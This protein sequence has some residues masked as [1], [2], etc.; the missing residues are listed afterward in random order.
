MYEKNYTVTSYESNNKLQLKLN[1]LFQWFTEISWEH[2]KILGVGFEEMN[3]SKVFWVLI[4]VK[5]KINK[6]PKWQDKVTL[7]TAPTGINGLY[8]S[9]EFIL[10]D[11]DKNVLVEADSKWLIIDKN[12]LRTIKPTEDE[13]KN[14]K[15]K[16]KNLD[17]EFKRMHLQTGLTNIYK[18]TVQYTDIDL[19]NHVNNAVYVRWIENIL[20]NSSYFL[21]SKIIIFSIQFLKEVMQNDNVLLCYSD[22]IDNKIFFEAIIENSD[23]HCIRAE[24]EL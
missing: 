10:I 4:G 20:N 22:I 11:E 8:F 21:K 2:A 17:I 1:C 23:I 24:I 13:Y 5:V 19:H 9:R 16:S 7:Q 15:I 18:E 14:L 6:L 3:N 12:T